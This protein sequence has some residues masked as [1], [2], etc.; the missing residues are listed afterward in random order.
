LVKNFFASGNFEGVLEK[1]LY[2][3]IIRPL[4]PVLRKP[5]VPGEL[6]LQKNNRSRSAKLRVAQ[7]NIAA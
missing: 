4:H 6:E 1:D 5:M 2:G 7:K 3:N